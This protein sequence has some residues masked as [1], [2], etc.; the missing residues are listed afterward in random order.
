MAN[1]TTTT[2]VVAG[3][4]ELVT[5]AQL[6]EICGTTGQNISALH[7]DKDVATPAP[8]FMIKTSYGRRQVELF[9]TQESVALWQDAIKANLVAQHD[10][11]L[12][13]AKAAQDRL[14]KAQEKAKA[15][16]DLVAK[17]T[18]SSK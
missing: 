1:N 17:L 2:P 15:A 4:V 12:A 13:K 14:V 10:A 11:I 6:A 7:R 9:W 8:S 16:Q 3:P 18:A 5:I